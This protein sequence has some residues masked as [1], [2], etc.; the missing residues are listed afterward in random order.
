MRVRWEFACSVFFDKPAM[1]D[2]KYSNL[3]FLTGLC[4]GHDA[5]ALSLRHLRI[6]ALENTRGVGYRMGPMSLII[7][8][9]GS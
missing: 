9:R 6:R 7:T 2:L 4:G 1:P 3:L 8:I 5:V